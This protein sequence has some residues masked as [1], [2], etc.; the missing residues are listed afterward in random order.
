MNVYDTANKLASEIKTS[1]EYI[2]YKKIKEYINANSVLKEK[3]KEFE[4][5]RYEAQI[6]VMQGKQDTEKLQEMQKLYSELL[7]N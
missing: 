1:S 2:E 6:D 5:S 4:K 3:V 7:Q